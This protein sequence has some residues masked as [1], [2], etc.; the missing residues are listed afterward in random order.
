MG[1]MPQRKVC[2]LSVAKLMTTAQVQ[3]S[4]E[5]LEK[6]CTVLAD[7]LRWL[8]IHGFVGTCAVRPEEGDECEG[9]CADLLYMETGTREPPFNRCQ[10]DWLPEVKDKA[11]ILPPIQSMLAP[12]KGV[13]AGLPNFAKLPTILNDIWR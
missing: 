9:G 6:C 11:A 5:L 4:P 2:I 10:W 13:V 12:L 1:R 8:T 3:G 7:L